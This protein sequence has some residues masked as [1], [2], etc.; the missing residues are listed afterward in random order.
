M[1]KIM[2]CMGSSCFLR[3]NRVNLQIIQKYLKE[4]K[5]A[6]EIE[7]CGCLCQ[8]ECSEG[9]NIKI[10]EKNYQGVDSGSLIEI[11]NHHFSEV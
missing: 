7:L 10:G 3:G 8:G 2:V 9:P 4:K 6:S 11:L 5:I 1:S